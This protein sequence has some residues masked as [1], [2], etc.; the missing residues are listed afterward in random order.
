MA[1]GVAGTTDYVS[2]GIT[3]SDSE[4][5]IQGYIE[6][7]YGL[8]PVLGD[9][10][11]NV[12]SS[13]NV[14][15]GGGFEGA[16]IDVAG[17]IKPK[18]LGPKWSP[19]IGYVHYFYAPEDV[20]PD[21]GEIYAKTDYTFGKDDRFTLRALVFFAPDFN[22]SGFTAHLGRRRWQGQ[23]VEERWRVRRRWIS[24]LRRS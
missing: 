17:G 22:Q 5:A 23:V 21:Y 20:S 24:V 14:D 7:S 16:E 9:L 4:P 15:F 8:G 19:N 3:Q 6:P 1:I 13:S 12:W 10:F 11:V 18:F 2:R